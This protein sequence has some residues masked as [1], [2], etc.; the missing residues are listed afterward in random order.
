VTE[1]DLKNNGLIG[2]IPAD[3]FLMPALSLLDLSK[4][5]VHMDGFTAVAE[6]D[7]LLS[8]NLA[9]TKVRSIAGIQQAKT[10]RSL[11][12]DGL[13]LGGGMIPT[14]LYALTDLHLLHL[15]FSGLVGTLHTELGRMKKLRQ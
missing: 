4:N 10:L 14:Q 1:V 3:L 8:L 5:A 12:L 6:S 7:S 13:D 11:Y 2:T 9:G 15:Q